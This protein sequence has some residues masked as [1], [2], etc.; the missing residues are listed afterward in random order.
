MALHIPSRI[1]TLQLSYLSWF[2]ETCILW[3]RAIQ[4]QRVFLGLLFIL[5][6]LRNFSCPHLPKT[7]TTRITFS[8]TRT[9]LFLWTSQSIVMK[10]WSI[11]YAF[12]ELYLILRR[13]LKWYPPSWL[14]SIRNQP[15]LRSMCFRKVWS[16]SYALSRTAIPT[17][18]KEGRNTSSTWTAKN[19]LTPNLGRIRS[20][21]QKSFRYRKVQERDSKWHQSPALLRNQSDLN[22]Y[23]RNL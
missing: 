5:G 22:L 15:G 11:K 6:K 7:A 21:C 16:V 1:R 17:N 8:P 9:E 12:P 2:Q 20:C 18:I 3:L 19:L 4:V 14:N 23:F 13:N 10:L